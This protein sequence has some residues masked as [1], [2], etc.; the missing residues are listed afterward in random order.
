MKITE[1]PKEL[2][3]L[4]SLKY[5][6]PPN[7]VTL[8][9]SYATI[10][11]IPSTLVNLEKLECDHCLNLKEIPKELV[12]LKH[13]NC[14]NC[15]L[16]THIPK[17]LVKLRYLNCFDC[18]LITHIPKELVNLEILH[19]PPNIKEIPKEFVNLTGLYCDICHLLSQ[20]GIPKELVK[21]KTL[22][23]RDCP[24]ITHIHSSFINLYNVRCGG[25]P[26]LIYVP[27]TVSYVDAS[28]E[29]PIYLGVSNY[30]R[31]IIESNYI[32]Y[33]KEGCKK[34]HDTIF[35]EL[36][37]RTWHPSRMIDWCWDEDEKKFMSLLFT[38]S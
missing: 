3:N 14:Y 21:L 20:K 10:Q 38:S 28:W 7:L 6:N 33:Y 2:V 5:H 24:L 11:Y 1:I 12:N 26:N 8:D 36:I 25:C 13:L 9:I 29:G 15:P 17:E 32:K 4:K 16:I 30:K 18:P 35:E 31:D 37:Q 23:C 19:C 22:F 34:L 27:S